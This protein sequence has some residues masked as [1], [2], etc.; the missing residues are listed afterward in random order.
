L[1]ALSSP[2]QPER[3]TATKIF[4]VILSVIVAAY[5]FIG[6]IG[7]GE[8]FKALVCLVSQGLAIN[9]AIAARRAFDKSKWGHGLIGLGL[10]V[11]FAMWSE[12]GLHHAWTADGS[13]ISP[14]LTWFLCAVEPVLF[15]FTESVQFAKKPKTAEEIADE[16]LAALRNKEP[17][18]E[19][20]S[21]PNLRAIAGGLTG[22]AAVLLTPTGAQ[23]H[24]P[25]RT[26]PMSLKADRS[27][28]RDQQEP[29]RTQ[30]RLLLSQGLTAYAVHKATGVPIST[31]KK[32]AK[33]AA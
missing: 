29:N 26:E 27:V 12:Q 20:K 9:A 23:A 2:Q 7:A 17:K 21:G 18:R 5:G 8:L 33:K 11:G 1:T 13:E 19:P 10:T 32:W 24:E 16:T 25:I 4:A 15:W 6:W 14:A 30:A 22:A 31:L 28:V 3:Y